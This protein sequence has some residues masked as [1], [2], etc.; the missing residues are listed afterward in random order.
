MLQGIVT[1]PSP[2]AQEGA[3]QWPWAEGAVTCFQRDVLQQRDKNCCTYLKCEAQKPAL[4][5][6]LSNVH[7]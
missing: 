7:Y 2:P 5:H 4:R 1:N 6:L 3:E